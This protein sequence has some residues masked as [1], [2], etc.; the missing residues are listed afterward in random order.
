MKS[1]FVIPILFA[2][3][4]LWSIPLPAQNTEGKSSAEGKSNAEGKS[5]KGQT[6][7]LGAAPAPP[8]LSLDPVE[9]QIDP[10]EPAMVSQK[11]IPGPVMLSGTY[12]FGNADKETVPVLLLHSHGGSR[13]DFAPL[14]DALANA[15]YA[16]LAVD[17]RGHGTS[18]KRFEVT[19]PQFSVQTIAQGRS[20][21]RGG[22]KTSTGVVP[23]APPSR[24]LVDFKDKD[25]DLLP[26]DYIDM[27]RYDLPVFREELLKAHDAGVCNMNRLVIIGIDRA[28]AVAAFQ[29]MQDW[30][31]KNSSRLTKTLI[32]IAPADIDVS[33]DTAK[34]FRDNKWMSTG[35]AVFFV[36]P[37]GAPSAQ[38][39]TGKIR[40]ELIGKNTG[41]ET[42]ESRFQVMTYTGEKKIKTD[43]GET[44]AP[45]TWPETFADNE[46]GVTAKILEFLNNRNTLFKEKE[47]RWSR[48]K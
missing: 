10:N 1:V 31:D 48:I 44:I 16:V 19:P 12:Y 33:L 18:N 26:K 41:D 21:N 24:R 43:K 23:T 2:G 37:L 14:I 27:V 20:G 28:A 17:L 11:P 38:M 35:L 6:Q 15:G 13:R 29:A 40:S 47:A 46:L 34:C 36:S 22:A 32:L 45:L 9:P 4:L 39:L 3:L 7:E 25:D 8:L 5:K 30:G 42:I